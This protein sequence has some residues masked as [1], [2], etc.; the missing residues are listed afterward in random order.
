M[1]HRLPLRDVCVCLRQL[2][3]EVKLSAR[4]IGIVNGSTNH[5]RGARL[6]NG[7]LLPHRQETGKRRHQRRRQDQPPPFTQR[8]KVIFYFHA[9]VQLRA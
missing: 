1:A 8:E 4:G 5:Q 2:L 6:I 9:V 3:A 7:W